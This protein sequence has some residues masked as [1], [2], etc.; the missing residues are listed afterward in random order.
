V[1]TAADEA[2][3]CD[4]SSLLEMLGKVPDPRKARGWICRLSFILA[5]SLAA[6]L[7]V[8]QVSARFVITLRIC[9]SRSYGSWAGSGVIFGAC[10][11]GRVNAQS[12]GY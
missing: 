10:S 11:S 3:E 8:R 7:A 12:V 9:R 4:I 2:Q 1:S 6:V 5:V